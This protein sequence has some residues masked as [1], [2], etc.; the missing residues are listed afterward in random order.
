MRVA[1]TS[2]PDVLLIEPD[3]HR[4]RR[5]IFFESFNEARWAEHLGSGTRFVQDN[6]TESAAGVLRGLH[7]Q[8]RRA[9]GKLVRVVRGEV[10]DVAVDLRRGS[11]HFGNWTGTVLSDKTAGELWV[12]PGFA[13]GYLVL[14]E[15]ATVLYKTTDYYAPAE[16]R[17]LRWND[18]EVGIRWP[19]TGDPILSERDQRGLPLSRAETY[20]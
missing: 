1:P 6:H 13:H 8:I 2:I 9:Q 4:D 5:G 16:E 17:C 12:P 20:P 7:Y 15:R 10:F 14:S 19:L 18:P 3:V 11:P